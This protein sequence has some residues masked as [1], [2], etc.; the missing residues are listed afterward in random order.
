MKGKVMSEKKKL[1]LKIKA[2]LKRGLEDP[3]DLVGRVA[4]LRGL[5]HIYNLQT[6]SEKSVEDTVLYN[7][8]GFSGFDGRI[9]TSIAQGF[10]Q[11]HKLTLKQYM[12]VAKKMQ[13]Y[14]KQLL[15][16]SLGEMNVDFADP[17]DVEKLLPKSHPQY[18][19]K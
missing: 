1:E 6:A 5:M 10:M 9:M 8:V 4:V 3:D 7:G 12:L 13:R 14:W 16:I 19:L 2:L 18:W 15:R 17:K 11:W